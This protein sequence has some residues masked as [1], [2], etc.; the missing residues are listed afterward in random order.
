MT[1]TKR[2]DAD[3]EIE[4]LSKGLA[5]LEALEGTSFEPVPL[6]RVMQRCPDLSRDTVMRTLKTFR[7][8]GYVVTNDRGEWTIGK[9]FLRFAAKATEAND[10]R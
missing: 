5:V 8:R 2:G 9:R 4:A 7:L 10:E 6:R 3:Y 1:M